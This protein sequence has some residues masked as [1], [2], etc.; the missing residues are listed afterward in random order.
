MLPS[1]EFYD[2]EIQASVQ[3]MM[4]KF[5]GARV[6]PVAWSDDW[7]Q[8]IYSVFEGT[9]AGSYVLQ[10][11]T[12]D[13][14]RV[15]ASARDDIDAA[16]IGEVSG[17]T[18]KARDD[19]TI[20][21]VLTWPP[22]SASETRTNL[23]LVVMPHGGPS[24]YDSLR[25]DWMAQYFANRGYL[26]L[27]PN[28]RG[29]SGYGAE[30]ERAGAGEWGGKM[31][32]D[33]SDG[34]QALI[35]SGMADPDRVCIV[36]ASYGGY[37][38]LAGGAFTPDLYKCVVAV[39]PVSDVNRMLRDEASQYGS[40]HWVVDY[41]KNQV[42][43]PKKEKARL[44]QISPVNA[45]EAFKAPVLLIHGR[46]DTVVPISQSRS[47]ETA[48]KRAGKDVTMVEMKGEDHWLSDGD[49]RIEALHAMSDFVDSH[50]GQ[51]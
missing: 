35:N 38:A 11:R 45:A 34:V 17:I 9:T 29:S 23:P 10:D 50:I 49:T 48:L 33:I 16:A 47:M 51:K 19:L 25:F 36:G 46:D 27:Q 44:E 20:P 43:D 5:S 18:Y 4:D 40:R 26:V 30:F 8:I 2:P 21:A 6:V 22:G 13:S 14:Y 1:Y 31:Q 41:W 37:A 7:K 15:I 28:F 24:S 3:A 32:D 42:G 12:D 39:A